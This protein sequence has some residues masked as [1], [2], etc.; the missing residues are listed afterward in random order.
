MASEKIAAAAKKYTSPSAL[1]LRELQTLTDIAREKN[2]VV[3]TT[4]G[5]VEEVGRVASMVK[6]LKERK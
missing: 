2:M 3:V 4:A 6:A 5:G 1:R